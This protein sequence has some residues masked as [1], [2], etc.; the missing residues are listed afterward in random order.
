MRSSVTGTDDGGAAPPRKRHR[1]VP[2]VASSV[3]STR[4]FEWY[5]QLK[6]DAIGSLSLDAPAG[7]NA[8]QLP[9][10]WDRYERYP[11]PPPQQVETMKAAV[12]MVSR[13]REENDEDEQPNHSTLL[14]DMTFPSAGFGMQIH[15]WPHSFGEG[16]YDHLEPSI[17]R[18]PVHVSP[19]RHDGETASTLRKDGILRAGSPSRASEYSEAELNLSEDIVEPV[20]DCKQPY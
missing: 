14:T 17:P 4:N 20:P 16:F 3:D 2:S 19:R 18:F 12:G 8:G 13:C 5:V 7:S 15:G 11:L 1:S 9:N 10:S 6:L